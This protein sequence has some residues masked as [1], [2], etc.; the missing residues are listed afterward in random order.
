LR[1]KERFM[2]I[3]YSSV[4][5]SA[6]ISIFTLAA[7][8]SSVEPSSDEPVTPVAAVVDE[9]EHPLATSGGRCP[10]T[11]TYCCTVCNGKKWCMCASDCPGDMPLCP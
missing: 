5:V 2:K 1:C 11:E 10:K 4:V 8:G 3:S 6:A 9:S 7:C